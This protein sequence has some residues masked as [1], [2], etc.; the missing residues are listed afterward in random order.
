ME[1]RRQSIFLTFILGLILIT[2]PFSQAIAQEKVL[3]QEK[4]EVTE[5]E[6]GAKEKKDIRQIRKEAIGM[7]PIEE[8]FNQ[9]VPSFKNR[10]E[11]EFKEKV[12]A[13]HPLS[14]EEAK[15]LKENIAKSLL[16]EYDR[17]LENNFE[18]E[19]LQFGYNF[20]DQPSSTFTPIE[21]VPV[22][23]DYVL[24]PDDTVIIQMW[25]MTNEVFKLTLTRDGKINLPKVG[26]LYLWGMNF[27]DAE[28]K[29]KEGL[30]RFYKDVQIDVT[31][32]S[33]RTMKVFILGEVKKAGG[34][35]I[36]SLSTLLHG[37]YHAGGPTKFG[38][39]RN[40]KL[41][42]KG[43]QE[44][45]F[46]L[47]QLLLYG[48]RKGDARLLSDD[49]IFVPSIGDV[50]GISG[51]V[52][53]PA[54]YEMTGQPKLS[55]IVKM[56]GGLTPS[57]YLQKIQ[58]NR[59]LA[60]KQVTI[61]ELE[62]SNLEDLDKSPQN[63]E[64]KNRD[65]ILISSIDKKKRDYVTIKGNVNRP[66]EYKMVA[67]MK[68][69]DLISEARGLLPETYMERA[70]ILRYKSDYTRE[71]I[72]FEVGQALK[73]EPAHDLLLKEWDIVE[74]KSIF[75]I[76]PKPFVSIT[77]AVNK[78]GTYRFV[79]GMKIS[80]LIYQGQDL[81]D[82]AYL[83]KAELYRKYYKRYT[84]GAGIPV[85]EG[86]PIEE[87][88]IVNLKDL[89]QKKDKEA[90]LALQKED[91]LVVRSVIEPKPIVT[92]TGAI[93]KPGTYRFVEGMKI[94]DLIY[95]GQDLKDTAYLEKAE[96]YRK[97]YKR[98]SHD[99]PMHFE[100][101]GLGKP[102]EEVLTVN[103]K[104]ILQKKD[105]EADLVLQKE[106]HLVVRSVIE[107]KPSVIVS[108][109]VNKPGTYRFVPGLRIS[110]LIYQA[111]DL[112]D[113][114]YLEKAEL[115]RKN[116][117]RDK[118]AETLIVNLKEIFE[119]KEADL[120]LEKEDHLFIRP[121]VELIEK[122][123]VNLGG[124]VKFPGTYVIKK[125]EKLGSVIERAG[126]FTPHAFLRGTILIRKTLGGKRQPIIDDL[127]RAQKRIL[128]EKEAEIAESNYSLEGKEARRIA[129][130]KKREALNLIGAKTFLGRIIIDLNDPAS[131]NLL[132]ED[133]DSLFIPTEPQAVLI[134]GEVYNP[135]SIAFTPGKGVDF[136]LNKVGGPTEKADRSNIYVIKPDGQVESRTTGFLEI[137]K[138]DIIV[139]PE[140]FE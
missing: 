70:E 42:R 113:T 105:K 66:G 110:D 124:E 32:G 123:T 56:G 132:L 115:Y 63:I 73:K 101:Y 102:L 31:L 119:N 4:K 19:I 85:E 75:D 49:I 114:A 125:G 53:I 88:L 33:L 128:L 118:P 18:K 81:K 95:Q 65:L 47:Y 27:N 100:D 15:V 30:A 83:E 139:V 86:K 116:Y 52:N 79:E 41:I 38:S 93:N 68:L 99:K 2:T 60:N 69:S 106:D 28:K 89:L 140:K 112:K 129:L 12:S 29:I 44:K 133:G 46:D 23:P 13:G 120:L 54:I 117:G 57:A 62:I 82:T 137:T 92:I 111:Q 16:D 91:H 8:A 77:G 7:S 130:A 9:R 58:V 22:G 127:I 121:V 6:L 96:L 3:P 78:P 76:F 87:L 122:W 17:R 67:D 71:I 59:I 108:G 34:Y 1:K 90:D 109:E 126:G 84:P 5:Q 21:S 14:S 104:D 24:G 43:E 135:E 72:P 25:G 40:I 138:G 61:V 10:L 136:Y 74:I 131:Q 94:S 45:V 98:Y 35:T 64:L 51:N 26:A 39:L 36:S 97:H 37:L 103:L 20:F 55:D 107:P 11:Q 48:D 50:V 80:D 134:V